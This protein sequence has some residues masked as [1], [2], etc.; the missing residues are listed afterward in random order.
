MSAGFSYPIQ[1]QFN[2]KHWIGKVLGVLGILIASLF[3]GLIAS[4]GSII[5]IA[6]L[7]GLIVGTFLLAMPSAA[8]WVIL[9]GGMV[10]SGLVGLVSEQV[11]V[12]KLPWAISLVG[13]LLGL[14]AIFQGITRKKEDSA[15]PLHLWCGVV[16]LIVAIAT[17]LVHWGSLWE[18]FTG[19]KRYFQVWGL[20]FALVLCPFVDRDYRRW[21][22]FFLLAA[23]IQ[24][25]FALYE[26]IWLVPQRE[27]MHILGLVPADVVAGTFGA[28]LYG[29]GVSGDMAAFQIAVMAFIIALWQEKVISLGKMLL[30]ILP[31]VA[32]LFLGETKIVVILL[33]LMLLVLF[34]RE[35]ISKPVI[36]VLALLLGAGLT[37]VLGYVYLVYFMK[38]TL[39]QAVTGTL[40]YNLYDKGY[41]GYLLNRFTA[42]PFW[43]DHHGAANP[44]EFFFGHGLGSSY[45]GAGALS[46]GKVALQYLGYGIGLTTASTLL[47]D[48]GLIGFVSFLMILVTAGLAARGLAS[49]S[50]DASIRA[51]A[52]GVEVAIVIL[53]VNLFYGTSIITNMSIQAAMFFMLGYLG[54]LSRRAL[55][56]DDKKRAAVLRGPSGYAAIMS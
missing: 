32:P 2:R 33:P 15:L 24:L 29:G 22:R 23:L 28:S 54:W 50:A 20:M 44:V 42:L 7:F 40:A 41:G 38:E 25:P 45:Y 52:R 9:A 46:L 18:F 3:I 10:F 37:Y 21:L 11:A 13:L 12:T 19:F 55:T 43:W 30:V 17:T 35:M 34:R 14:L 4:T 39:D 49:R 47:W 8:V 5:L 36:G 6:M 51:Q 26:L 31:I 48:T 53:I 16:F 56:A 1:A 27:T